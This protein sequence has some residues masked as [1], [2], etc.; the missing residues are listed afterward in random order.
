MSALRKLE[1]EGFITAGTTH[2]PGQ[3]FYSITS[4]GQQQLDAYRG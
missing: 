2:N 3:P 1:Q 4:T